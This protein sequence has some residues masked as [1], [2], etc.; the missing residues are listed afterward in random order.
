VTGVNLIC[1]GCSSNYDDLSSTPVALSGLLH[2][3]IMIVKCRMI[4]CAF[5]VFVEKLECAHVWGT[6]SEALVCEA[7]V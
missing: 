2:C 6:Y 5:C 4:H 1:S 3:G 7:V